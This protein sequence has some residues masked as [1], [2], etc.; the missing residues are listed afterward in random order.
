M[1]LDFFHRK[2]DTSASNQAETAL[3][4]ARVET[5]QEADDGQQ[6]RI[7]LLDADDSFDVMVTHPNGINEI[8]WSLV[9][10]REIIR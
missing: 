6:Y 9:R 3:N 10:E 5:S 2:P 4:V 7:W 8:V 1:D